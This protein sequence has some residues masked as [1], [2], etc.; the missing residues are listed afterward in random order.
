ME[1]NNRNNTN[2]RN[3]TNNDGECHFCD[4]CFEAC[5]EAFKC[6][7]FLKCEVFSDACLKMCCPCCDTEE[8][9]PKHKSIEYS[10]Y[11]NKSY[12]RLGY[13]DYE[14]IKLKKRSIFTRCF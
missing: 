11:E 9:V 8:I 7:C 6:I 14:K 13:I 3:N 10:F 5:E 1:N 4:C 2:D 12:R